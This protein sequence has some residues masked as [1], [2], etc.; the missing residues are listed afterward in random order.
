MLGLG[1]APF[2]F[3]LVALAGAVLAFL[4]C[5]GAVNIRIAGLRGFSVGFGFALVAMHWIVE[6]FLVDADRYGMLAP[7]ALA[8]MAAGFG[9]FWGVGFA[10]AQ[11]LAAGTGWRAGLALAVCWTLAELARSYIFTGLPWALIAYTWID[12]P[13]YHL[14][15][16]FGPHGIT[17]MTLG[18]SAILAAAVVRSAWSGALLAASIGAIAWFAGTLS[19]LPPDTEGADAPILRIVQPNAPQHLKWDPDWR[20]V[21][22]ERLLALSAEPGD[23]DVVIW[24]EVAVTFAL[25]SELA[26]Y[27]RISAA[28]GGKPVILGGQRIADGRARNSALVLD[29]T[30]TPQALYDKYHLVPFGEYM[31]GGA[32]VASLGIKGLA[33]RSEFGFVAGPGPVI[34]ETLGPGLRFLPMICYEA[35]FPHEL[36]RVGPTRPDFLL[37]MTNDAWF[38]KFAGPA[39]HLAQARARA[40]EFGL[41]VVRAANTGI[42]GVIDTQGRV[43]GRIDL[44]TAGKADVSLPAAHGSTTYWRNGDKPVLV[45]LFVAFAILIFPR[46]RKPVDRTHRLG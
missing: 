44:G 14:A 8:A 28:A 12:T 36:R 18:L 32:L 46:I 30:G 37:H 20:D 3:W 43:I 2:G 39:Q 23:P 27:D 16:E 31:P 5:F 34:I 4:R 1:Q 40:I 9:T 15:A 21:F 7:F 17:F 42:S 41:P 22:F 19:A 10:V 38:G 35:I 13:V 11:W 6:P 26:P 45:A 24:P 29:E 25:N 33:D